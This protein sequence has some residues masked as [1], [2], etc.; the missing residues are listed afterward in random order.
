MHHVAFIK[1]MVVSSWWSKRTTE[2]L[3]KSLTLLEG[4]DTYQ[5]L[6]M[7]QIRPYT[8]S[9]IKEMGGARTW[10]PELDWWVQSLLMVNRDRDGRGVSSCCAALRGR[11]GVTGAATGWLWSEKVPRRRLLLDERG[12]ASASEPGPQS[13]AEDPLQTRIEVHHHHR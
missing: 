5:D 2:L 8:G 1:T 11:K 3:G 6:K 13:V 7:S 10:E 9:I 12:G 4:G